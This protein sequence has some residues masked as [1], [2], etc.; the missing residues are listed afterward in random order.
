ML[1]S[2]RYNSRKI[3]PAY[4][5]LFSQILRQGFIHDSTPQPRWNGECPLWQ[6][7][8]EVHK[9]EYL[10]GI[11]AWRRVSIQGRKWDALGR[12]EVLRAAL[13][14]VCTNAEPA[15]DISEQEA[16]EGR[17]SLLIQE[18][19][20]GEDHHCKGEAADR[21]CAVLL[22]KNSEK[23][24]IQTKNLTWTGTSV[25]KVIG[26]SWH[27]WEKACFLDKRKIF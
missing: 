13:L 21:F 18:L 12:T 24:K 17:L 4:L 3:S 10:V 8:I 19:G 2:Q 1:F 14:K 26:Q 9:R 6:G 27:N 20:E 5:H 22:I 15:F 11:G 16:F 25:L 7:A 23:E